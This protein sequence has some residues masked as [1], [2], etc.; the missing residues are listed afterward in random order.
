MSSYQDFFSLSMFCRFMPFLIIVLTILVSYLIRQ[1]TL[2]NIILNWILFIL[3]ITAFFCFMSK[4][5]LQFFFLFECSVIFIIFMLFFWGGYSSRYEAG[6][7][8]IL[9]SLLSSIPFIIFCLYLCFLGIFRFRYSFIFWNSSRYIR[10]FFYWVLLLKL[11]FTL[12][13]CGS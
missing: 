1:F 13:I 10:V 9:Y 2:I 12:F 3:R 4:F 7:Y 6:Y 11:L 5:F 8:F